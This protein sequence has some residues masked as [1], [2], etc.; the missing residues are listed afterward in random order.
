MVVNWNSGYLSISPVYTRKVVSNSVRI[1][2]MCV[3]VR[4]WYDSYLHWLLRVPFVPQIDSIDWFLLMVN[5]SRIFSAIPC[6][7]WSHI[8]LDK[9]RG[10]SGI[11]TGW[12]VRKEDNFSYSLSFCLISVIHLMVSIKPG[13]YMCC[14]AVKW[15]LKFDTILIWL[16]GQSNESVKQNWELCLSAVITRKWKKLIG[17]IWK[18]LPLRLMWRFVL[19]TLYIVFDISSCHTIRILK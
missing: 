15:S 7:H 10:Y 11:F 16:Q 4:E 12:L 8:I 14:Q 2:S 19:Y 3:T 13:P 9:L 1:W 17:N 6:F 18:I 5:L